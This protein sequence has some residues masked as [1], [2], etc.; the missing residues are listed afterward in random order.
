ME[1]ILTDAKFS[2]RVHL[3]KLNIEEKNFEQ[4]TELI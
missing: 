1:N 3:L 4:K 2:S